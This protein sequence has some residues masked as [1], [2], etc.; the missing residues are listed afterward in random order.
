MGRFEAHELDGR[1]GQALCERRAVRGEHK[2]RAALDH[3]ELGAHRARRRAQVRGGNDVE[4]DLGRCRDLGPDRAQRAKP[5]PA[6][7][8]EGEACTG[9][10]EPACRQLTLKPGS[11][12][13][14][15]NF[16]AGDAK[17]NASGDTG[18]TFVIGNK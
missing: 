1:H 14:S 12:A 4:H 18:L 8:V 9:D 10:Q 2:I 3:L 5:A 7:E 11:Y 16:P 17:Y 6:P 13:L 15:A